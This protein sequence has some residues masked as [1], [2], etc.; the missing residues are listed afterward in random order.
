M[1]LIDKGNLQNRYETEFTKLLSS[2]N[3]S[4]HSEITYVRRL[5]LLQT[6]LSFQYLA[7][8]PFLFVYLLTE[9]LYYYF[10]FLYDYHVNKREFQEI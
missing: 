3:D 2:D 10:I 7:R 1:N 6:L 5:R 8:L 9:L 4:K